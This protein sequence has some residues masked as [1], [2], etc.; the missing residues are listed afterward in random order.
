MSAAANCG[1]KL[2]GAALAVV[3][4]AGAEYRVK[5]D[6]PSK[7]ALVLYVLAGPPIPARRDRHITEDIECARRRVEVAN[8]VD[9]E[10]VARLQLAT[11]HVPLEVCRLPR[12]RSRKIAGPPIRDDVPARN[13]REVQATHA[14]HSGPR[15]EVDVPGR[16]PDSDAPCESHGG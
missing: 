6:R 7:I 5:A 8:D 2:E 13:R 1:A 15:L 4:G 12:R 9:L 10:L 14:E 16:L 11:E 3:E